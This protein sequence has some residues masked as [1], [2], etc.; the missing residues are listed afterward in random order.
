V[1]R[2]FFQLATTPAFVLQQRF[3]I[4]IPQP[5]KILQQYIFI[6]ATPA[7]STGRGKIFHHFFISLAVVA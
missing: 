1:N 7:Q 6:I 4:T 2:I 5:S 3:L